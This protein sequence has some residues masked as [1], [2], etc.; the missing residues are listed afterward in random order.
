MTDWRGLAAWALASYV[1]HWCATLLL[2]I[3]PETASVDV[4]PL[5]VRGFGAPSWLLGLA[6]AGALSFVPRAGPLLGIAAGMCVVETLAFRRQRLLDS[7]CLLAAG[8]L[9]LGVSRIGHGAWSLVFAVLLPLSFLRLVTIPFQFGWRAAAAIAVGGGVLGLLFTRGRARWTVPALPMKPVVLA[10]LLILATSAGANHWKERRHLDRMAALPK[11]AAS[12]PLAKDY[13]H[14]GVSFTA[15]SG[16][17]YDNP[18]SLETLRRLPDFGVDAIALVPFGFI[19]RDSKT[20]RIAGRRE[21]WEN[22]DGMEILASEARALGMRV[23]LKPHVWRLQGKP[24]M[25][26]AEAVEW[27]KQYEPFIVHYAKFAERIRADAFCIGTELRALTQQENEW[28][29]IVRAVRREYSGAITYAANHGEEFETIRFWDALDWIGVDNYYPLSDNYEPKELL[30]KLETVQTKF[31]KPVLFTEAGFGAHEGAHKEP[32]EDETA[33]PLDLAEQAKSYEG[34]LSAVYRKP[35]FRGVYWWKVGTNG[36]GGPDNNS[37]TP[38][39][40]PAMEIVK[41]YYTSP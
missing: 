33:K 4:S 36:Y 15:E 9:A 6:L 18:R 23:M 25:P 39:R 38:W 12:R 32:W 17:G 37:M 13:F 41:K 27:L 30:A 20:I 21:S 2:A 34:L 29:G 1:A 35:W 16:I 3:H 22:E 8:L 26:R 28:R 24:A 31:N 19:G 14:K 11:A 10:A 40:K 5:A 7:H